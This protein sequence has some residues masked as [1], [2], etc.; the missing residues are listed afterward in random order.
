MQTKILRSFPRGFNMEY[1]WCIFMEGVAN[2]ILSLSPQLVLND[3]ILNASLILKKVMLPSFLLL[4]LQEGRRVFL[5]LN[6]PVD[7]SHTS[8]DTNFVF[9]F[10]NYYLG[11]FLCCRSPSL[12]VTSFSSNW[13]NFPSIFQ[14]YEILLDGCMVGGIISSILS[15]V[16]QCFRIATI[17]LNN[18]NWNTKKFLHLNCRCSDFWCKKSLGFKMLVIA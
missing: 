11:K 2:V 8:K 10:R 15:S 3:D 17:F 6:S 13:I 5:F 1:M 7:N 16:S 12:S 4:P 18:F 14:L 9:S